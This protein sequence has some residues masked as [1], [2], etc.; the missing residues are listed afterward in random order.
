M[1]FAIVFFSATGNTRKFALIIQEELMKLNCSIDSYDITSLTDRQEAILFENYDSI[2]FGFPIY[3]KFPPKVVRDWLSELKGANKRCAMFFSYGG[4]ILGEIHNFTKE[5][6]EKKGFSII[7]SAEFLGKHSFNVA[8]GFE[9]L[10]NRPNEE[11]IQIAREYANE[12]YFKFRKEKLDEIEFPDELPIELH[13]VIKNNPKAKLLEHYPT[14][15]E[16]ECSMCRTCEV[17][18][19]TG[20]FSADKGIAESEK[21]IVC[22]RCVFNCPDQVIIVNDMTEGFLAFMERLG[23]T[24]KVL[25]EKKSKYYL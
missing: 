24:P 19:P 13:P 4:V 5:L 10:P 12:I 17:N 20:A 8:E 21:C 1:K 25:N 11:D 3:G 2:I 18:C 16:K 7:A 9:L 23:V 14:R 6:L 22:M 15:F